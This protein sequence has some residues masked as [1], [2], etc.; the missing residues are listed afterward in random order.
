MDPRDEE[1]IRA[2]AEAAQ[3]L[4]LVV[5]HM[6]PSGSGNADIAL[7]DTSGHRL[8]VNIKKRSTVTPM[9][10][11]RLQSEASGSE[12]TMLV[13]VA[14][15]VTQ[16]AR[17][18]LRESGIG[19]LDL[20]GHLRLVGPGLLIDAEVPAS[21]P[22]PARAGAI[23]ASVGLE[24]ACLLLMNPFETL[25][26]R[27]IA[28]ALIR[29]A[30]TVSDVL[31]SLREQRLV[32]A[33]NRPLLPDLFW[34]TADVWKPEVTALAQLPREGEGPTNFLLEL[35]FD[36]IESTRGWALAGTMAA[37]AYG[38][39]LAVK[40]D[41]PPDFHVPAQVIAR[42]ATQYLGT[43]LSWETR[44]ATVRVAPVPA[45]CL[46]RIDLATQHWPIAHPVF[47]ALDLAQDPA[48]GR[49]VLAEWTPPEPWHRVW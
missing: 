38:A 24:V 4:G 23:G 31:S 32:T 41:Y 37:M 26:V 46:Q 10:A 11:A 47:V 5:T 49:E 15:R 8:A 42:R 21:R 6:P 25:G 40:T 48:R 27:E 3:S 28:R 12:D 19:W 2:L 43:P 18:L 13:L 35:G 7:L 39:P 44:A 29:S 16:D 14:D 33:G 20:R 22:R 36:N 9:D 34:E 30:S 17:Q 1:A 45:V